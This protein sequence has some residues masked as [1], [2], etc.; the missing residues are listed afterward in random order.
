[1]YSIQSLG[2]RSQ[3]SREIGPNFPETSDIKD[4]WDSKLPITKTMLQM[5]SAAHIP[6]ELLSS[7]VKDA[8]FT[9]WDQKNIPYGQLTE[10]GAN[11]LINI[12]K[13]LRRRYV[14]TLINEEHDVSSLIYCRSTHFC[15]TM[16]SLRSLLSGFLD[17][18]GGSY[19][20]KFPL[21]PIILVRAKNQETMFPGADGPCL[22]MIEKRAALLADGIME[23][24][25]P[26]F[27]KLEQKMKDVLGYS[28]KV[29]W[30]P[31][32]EILT[33][34]EAHGIPFPEGISESDAD[35]VTDLA[36][37]MWGT[38]YNDDSL[39]RLAIGRFLRELIDVFH[40]AVHNLPIPTPSST[41][42]FINPTSVN[43]NSTE[44]DGINSEA[45]Y[46][47]AKMMIFSG[48]DSTVRIL[49]NILIK[50]FNTKTLVYN[51]NFSINI[52]NSW[53]LYCVP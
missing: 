26:E 18:D 10:L 50:H 41:A 29:T 21:L 39:N 11:Q 32:K 36:G 31:I 35:R 40:P 6:A 43:P 52:H 33:C 34:Y 12:G 51:S 2:D 1:L 9:G 27:L 17:V 15:R 48:H 38:L 42:Q 22:S 25:I 37:W 13:E 47:H 45:N 49:I 19:P 28:D 23:N 7:H 20:Q 16:Q 8:V 5:A 46:N 4:I 44:S 14:G 30:L 3:I 53:Y 24:S